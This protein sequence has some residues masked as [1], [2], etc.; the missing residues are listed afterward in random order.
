MGGSVASGLRLL[1]RSPAAPEVGPPPLHEQSEAVPVLWPQFLSLADVPVLAIRG[2]NSDILSE[3]TLEEMAE[4]HPRL[5]KHVVEDQGHA[6]LL[7]DAETLDRIAEF[8]A[9]CDE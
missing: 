5:E 1:P 7:R 2:E 9:R 4:R 6:P 3:S 8:A